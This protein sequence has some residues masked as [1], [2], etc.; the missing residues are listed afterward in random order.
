MLAVV[1]L[2]PLKLRPLDQQ[3]LAGVWLLG[4]RLQF[5]GYG[6]RGVFLWEIVIISFDLELQV[7]LSFAIDF[8]HHAEDHARDY[9]LYGCGGRGHCSL[10]LS[11]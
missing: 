11:I 9:L 3:V 7:V 2:I 5:R 1:W 6:P 4:Y 10:P 8:R